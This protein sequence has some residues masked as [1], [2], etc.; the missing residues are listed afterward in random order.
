MERVVERN[1]FLEKLA[2][3][4]VEP[5]ATS[6][7]WPL[8]L[9]AA[10]LFDFLFWGKVPG[11]SFPIFVSVLLICGYAVARSTATT[12]AT[13]AKWLLLPL[14]VFSLGPAI[15]AE[16]FTMALDCLVTLVLL[17]LL[18]DTL[19]RGSWIRYRFTDYIVAF[20]HLALAGVARGGFDIAAKLA[21]R[22]ERAKPAGHYRPVLRGILLSL[23]VLLIFGLLLAS[24]DLVF[25][26][27]L[28]D[29]L[30]SLDAATVAEYAFRV[31]YVMVLA[32]ALT[33][34][35]LHAVRPSR[36][37]EAGEPPAPSTEGRGLG[38]VEGSIVLGSLNVLFALFVIVQFRYFFA[39]SSAIGELGMTYSEY[40][41]RGFGELVVVALLTLVLLMG[42][43]LF[44]KKDSRRRRNIFLSLSSGTVVLT[45]I[46]LV[47]AF[48]RLLLYEDAYGFT[49]LRTYS[50]VFMV[51]L[52]LTL[53]AVLVLQ[54][55]NS[56]RWMAFVLLLAGLG[57]AASLNVIGVDALIARS[58]IDRAIKGAEFDVFYLND[59][60][61]DAVPVL[62][63]KVDDLSGENMQL[64]SD[65][66]FCK[67]VEVRNESR[68][69]QSIHLSRDRARAALLLYH[70]RVSRTSRL[71]TCGQ[72]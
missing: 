49:R 59:L 26:R 17:G 48:Q 32:Y 25:S 51:W 15:R 47:S 1:E 44:V 62:L 23:P 3:F 65:V 18:A 16:P 71:P 45:G 46:I 68:P 66:L 50:H 54:W 22:A 31:F 29:P 70:D 19:A 56:L 53:L 20:V 27:F 11:I 34:L 6:L 64:L 69:W 14:A 72:Y 24:A 35:L 63:A 52:G 38:T 28:T 41:R 60:S 33:G 67:A 39:G 42:L 4:E 21:K 30:P 9:G 36:P 55:K 5:T 13:S 40:A 58:N 57:Y 7:V 2:T 8:A 61:S 12:I 43:G 37:A 10:W